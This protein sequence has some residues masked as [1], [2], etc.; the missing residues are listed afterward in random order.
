MYEFAELNGTVEEMTWL[1]TVESDND[2]I[3]WDDYF[4]EK[5]TK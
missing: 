5:S 4:A 2:E 1:A 3:A